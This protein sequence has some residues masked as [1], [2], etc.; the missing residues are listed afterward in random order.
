MKKISLFIGILSLSVLSTGL[1][2]EQTLPAKAQ[3]DAI[4]FIR[5]TMASKVPTMQIDDIVPSEVDGIYEL[6]ADGEIYYITADAKYIF[7]GKL[8]GLS[9]GSENLTNKSMALWNER[10]APIRQ[11][12]IAAIA[13]TDMVVFK[14]ENEKHVVT[15]FTDVD[16]GYCRKLH[17]EMEEYNDLGITVRYMAYPRAGKPSDSYDKL[18][19]VWCSDDKQKSMTRAKNRQSVAA[20]SCK[21][22]IDSHMKIVRDFGLSGTPAI[23]TEGGQLIGGYVEPEKL[24]D[25]LEQLKDKS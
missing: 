16:C 24:V 11:Q 20:K 10:Q 2:A 8:L 12:K 21:H 4:N 9:N 25:Y 19:A 1:M 22:P 23:I 13:E 5:L 14:A 17:N 15:V 3:Q 7:A 6:F 18:A